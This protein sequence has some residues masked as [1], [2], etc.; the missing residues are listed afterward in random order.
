MNNPFA[1]MQ[2][3]TVYVQSSDGER[4]GPYKTAVGSKNSTHVA[5]IYDTSFQGREGWTLIRML[6]GLGEETYLILESN[7]SHGLAAI[8]PH[9]SLKLRKDASLLHKSQPK[10]A[11]NITINNSQGIQIGDHNVQHIAGSLQGLVQMIEQ[12]S[13]A[14]EEKEAAKGLLVKLLESP[15]VASVLGGVT[16]GVM[17]YLKNPN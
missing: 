16:T 12:S 10:A 1:H 17:A 15:V 7:F 13:A 5:S 4:F 3:D 11:P 2:N 6:P 8:G 14:H 9:W